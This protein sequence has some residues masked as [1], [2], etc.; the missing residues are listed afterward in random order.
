M[1][2]KIILITV[3]YMLVFFSSKAQ[4]NQYQ[5]Q[6]VES[7]SNLYQISNIIFDARV[8]LNRILDLIESQDSEISYSELNNYAKYIK[9]NIDVTES[10]LELALANADMCY[11][12]NGQIQSDELLV[13]IDNMNDKNKN[14]NKSVKLLKKVIDKQKITD[15]LS[16]IDTLLN[17]LNQICEKASEKAL[18]AQNIC[19]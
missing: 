11:C 6:L 12:L 5:T 16:E 14:I 7:V 8:E 19:N 9:D 18:N 4:C 1:H 17:E 2:K 3:F 10:V 13:M 15:I